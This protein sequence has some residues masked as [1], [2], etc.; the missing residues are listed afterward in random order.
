VRALTSI[1]I[2]EKESDMASVPP[3]E[4]KS[5]ALA[6]FQAPAPEHIN[7]AQAV[8]CYALLRMDE[9][10]DLITEARYFGG[11]IS[12]MG[13]LCGAL[14]GLALALGMR[15]RF[16]AERGIAGP[17]ST[18]DQL[19]SILRDFAA[20]SGSCRCRDLTGYDLSTP[21]GMIEFRLSD[22]RSRCNDYVA[23]AMDRLEPLLEPALTT[24]W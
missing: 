21:D 16:L 15:D 24:A 10:V 13:E 8:V 17:D 6:R 23:W 9:D 19:K 12:G 3:E 4:A 7:C 2:K 14:N 20:E 5:E 1:I 11:G 22:I 18:G